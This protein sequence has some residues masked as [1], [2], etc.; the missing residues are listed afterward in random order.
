MLLHIV[1]EV[2]LFNH[3][4]LPIRLV[5]GRSINEGRVEI[6]YKNSWA[7]VCDDEWDSIDATIVCNQL[8]FGT[9]SA[10]AFTDAAFGEGTGIILLDTVSCTTGQSSIFDCR[11]NGFEN[12]DCSHNEDAGVRCANALSGKL[13]IS[14][15][16]IIP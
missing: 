4:G 13:R 8:G 12:H 2:V 1:I 11:H 7:T 6:Y 5:D 15:R 16:W 14:L 9:N 10:Q 3:S